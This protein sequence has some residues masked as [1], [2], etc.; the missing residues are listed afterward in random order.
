MEEDISKKTVVV[1][2]VLT[3]VIS[4]VGT[5]IVLEEAQ[6]IK[7]STGQSISMENAPSSQTAG[8]IKL[9]IRESP[10]LEG[11]HDE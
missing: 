3:I 6:K 4:V 8:I 7:A 5:L 9:G 2:L 1:L 11:V 10:E